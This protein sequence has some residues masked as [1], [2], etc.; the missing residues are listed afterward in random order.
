MKVRIMII[1]ILS[2]GIPTRSKAH[3][4]GHDPK[5]PD[6]AFH[7]HKDLPG[8]LLEDDK[9]PDDTQKTC[10]AR[11]GLWRHHHSECETKTNPPKDIPN[12]PDKSLCNGMGGQW[13]DRGHS[14]AP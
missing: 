12:V 2:A 5:D 11:R 1:L 13:I 9:R 10:E 8:Q 7:C 14:T 6:M 4:Y 3:V